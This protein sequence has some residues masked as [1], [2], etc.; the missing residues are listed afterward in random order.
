MPCMLG[1]LA[2][3]HISLHRGLL[4]GERMQY[5]H[6]LQLS[7]ACMFGFVV[8]S[9]PCAHDADTLPG[10]RTKLANV[11]FTYELSRRWHGSGVEVGI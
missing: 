10:G 8:G 7:D 5:W 4:H 3:I 11:L 2:H 6:A 9:N 1:E